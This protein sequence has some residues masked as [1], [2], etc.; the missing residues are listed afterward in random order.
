M[1]Q[2]DYYHI[3]FY[4][5]CFFVGAFGLWI[6]QQLISWLVGNREVIA[7]LKL[8]NMKI[9]EIIELQETNL[10]NNHQFHKAKEEQL[11]NI[12]YKLMELLDI[13]S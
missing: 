13:W 4:V 11:D 9:D 12:N 7:E 10:T 3:L 2:L 1:I 5:L 6:A 8:V